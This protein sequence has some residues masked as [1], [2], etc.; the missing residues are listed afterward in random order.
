MI[1]AIIISIIP[2]AFK[3]DT[4]LFQIADKVVL[5]IFICDYILRLITADY[6]YNKMSVSSFI[7]YPFS[8]MAIIDLVAI[9]PSV[10]ILND[11]LKL[12]R[13]LRMIRASRVLRVFKV[14]RYSKS[15]SII[16]LL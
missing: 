16:A 10:T 8:F 13:I 14:L 11:G 1:A 4:L 9:L 7:K 12:L 15:M 6:K 3:K 2:L 5:V